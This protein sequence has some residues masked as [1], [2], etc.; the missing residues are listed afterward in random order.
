MDDFNKRK[1]IYPETTQGANFV[2]DEN[3]YVVD[4][5]C[6]ILTGNNLYFL[7]SILSSKLYEFA[8]KAIFSSVELGT[9]GYQYNKHALCKLPVILPNTIEADELNK[10]TGFSI[11]INHSFDKD[12]INT[13]DNMIFDI[14]NIS[15][16]EKEYIYQKMK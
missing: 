12:V 7:A 6:F 16:E 14:Y 1:I 8:Y 4:K 10:I 3:K 2:V 5:T 13:I 11:K 9:S 15:L